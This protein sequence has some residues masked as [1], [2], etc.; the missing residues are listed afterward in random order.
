MTRKAQRKRE[1]DD[2]LHHRGSQRVDHAEMAS[3]EAKPAVDLKP[4][5]ISE[6]AQ[7]AAAFTPSL[8]ARA[9]SWGSS[10]RRID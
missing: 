8:M 5:T 3:R 6:A 4:L 7:R 2:R 9:R 10:R 1:V